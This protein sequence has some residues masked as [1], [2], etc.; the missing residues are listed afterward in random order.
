MGGLICRTALQRVIGSPETVVSKLCTLGTP[1]GGIDVKLGGG[2]G[3][4]I[5]DTF[6]PNGSDISALLVCGS[7]CCLTAMTGTLTPTRRRVTGTLAESWGPFPSRRVLSVV[8]TNARDYDV[9]LGLSAKAM[10]EQ[11][12]GLVA[13]KN[14]YVR[15]SLAPTCTGR[16]PGAT[17]S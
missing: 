15:G 2:I 12:D 10:G 3:D 11:S 5:I 8:G 13:I 14:A 7:T 1:H 4:W 16:T 17:A 9:A 6:G